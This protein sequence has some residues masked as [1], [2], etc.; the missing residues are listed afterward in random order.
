M[1]RWPRLTDLS[2]AILALLLTLMLW[3]TG[4]GAELFA[5]NDF[6]DVAAVMMAFVGSFSLLWRRSH[7][8]QVHTAV[9]ALMLLVYSVTPADGLVAMTFSLFSLGRYEP[10]RAYSMLGVAA[11]VAFVLFNRAV[12]TDITPGGH[13]D[14]RSGRGGLVL[15]PTGTVSRRIPTSTGGTGA[16]SGAGATCRGR[17]R[18]QRRAQ[19]NSA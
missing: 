5:L 19:P 2:L 12:M 6:I 1:E 8:W 17:T 9:M 18:G 4:P 10:N 15:G 7:P 16:A 11:A 14:R 3:S 13:N